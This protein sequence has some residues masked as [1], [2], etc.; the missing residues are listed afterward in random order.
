MH[1]IGTEVSA[2]YNV[3][4]RSPYCEQNNTDRKELV[5]VKIKLVNQR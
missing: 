5:R 3:N 4:A 2:G 1:Q